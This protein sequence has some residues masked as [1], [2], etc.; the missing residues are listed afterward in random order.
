MA[1]GTRRGRMRQEQLWVATATLARPA[2]HPFCERLNG[3]LDE[4]GFDEFVE[5]SCRRFYATSL[6]RPSLVPGMYFRL[7]MVDISRA[8]IASVGSPGGRQTRW[9]SAPFYGWHWTSRCRTKQ[10]S[11]GPED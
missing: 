3:L 4:C 8:S 10:P 7:L 11:R 5:T 2:N 6:G 9:A 1:T